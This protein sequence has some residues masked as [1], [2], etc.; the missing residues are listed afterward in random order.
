[1]S[2]IISKL[3]KKLRSVISQFKRGQ[4]RVA[5]NENIVLDS[6]EVALNSRSGHKV[7]RFL[8]H[9]FQHQRIKRVLGS[10]LA[11]LA[12]VISFVPSQTQAGYFGEQEIFNVE[13]TPLATIVSI[14]FPT[15]DQ[16]INQNYHGYHTGIDFEGKTGDPVFPVMAGKIIEV[17]HSRV[18]YGNAI[19]IEHDEGYTSLYAHLSKINVQKGD[20]VKPITKVGEVGS[21]GRSTGDHLHFEVHED[22]RPIDPRL[23]LPL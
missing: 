21:T 9:F 20:E 1:M 13:N 16:K 14:V 11:L 23:I 8:R 7:S 4:S 5:K 22:G 15:K 12:I 17:Q 19:L 6:A 18:G 10:N 2:N 3:S